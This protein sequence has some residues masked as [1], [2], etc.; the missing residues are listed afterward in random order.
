MAAMGR[1]TRTGVCFL[2]QTGCTLPMFRLSSRFWFFSLLYGL[3]VS[4]AVMGYP[5]K[6]GGKTT[7]VV[8]GLSIVRVN[9]S[10]RIPVFVVGFSQFDFL[11]CHF[12]PALQG[13]QA[14]LAEMNATFATYLTE[15]T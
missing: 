15:V 2:L 9:F 13:P 4:F 7:Y 14:L 3:L 10:N 8:G 12:P 5:I 6:H 1:Q 11:T